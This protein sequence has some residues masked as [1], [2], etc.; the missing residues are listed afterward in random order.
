MNLGVSLKA[1]RGFC[2]FLGSPPTPTPDNSDSPWDARTR[3]GSLLGF[4][5]SHSLRSVYPCSWTP[6]DPRGGVSRLPTAG[7]AYD[8]EVSTWVSVPL[9][10]DCLHQRATQKTGQGRFWWH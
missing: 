1:A 3:T 2:L 4:T 5:L 7:V 8:V 9:V 6:E 10:P